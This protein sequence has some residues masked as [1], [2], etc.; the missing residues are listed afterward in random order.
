MPSGP[1]TPPGRH[2]CDVTA[3]VVIYLPACIAGGRKLTRV[4]VT[5]T[6]T[7]VYT[8]ICSQADWNLTVQL[9]NTPSTH[10]AKG[11]PHIYTTA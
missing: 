4:N 5:S 9:P 10:C 7:E 1:V 3:F 8:L 11:T 6:W 2:G